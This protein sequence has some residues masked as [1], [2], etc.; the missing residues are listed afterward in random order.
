MM[1]PQ[2]MQQGAG[3][4]PAHPPNPMAVI[5][6]QAQQ[7]ASQAQQQIAQLQSQITIDAV[8]RFFRDENTRSF[9]I[10]IETD[11]TIMPDE[12]AEKQARGEFLQAFG[13]AS[14]GMQP[15]MQMGPSGAELAGVMLKFA[16]APYRAGRQ[17]DTAI[18]KFVEQAPQIVQQQ[19]QAQQ[20][21]GQSQALEQAQQQL[22]QAELGKAQ[23]QLQKTQADAQL[24]AQQLQLDQQRDQSEA[25]HRQQTFSLE[26][27][28][29]QAELQ[30][31]QASLQETLARVEQIQAQTRIE[32]ENARTARQTADNDT[33]RVLIEGGQAAM[34]QAEVMTP[35]LGGQGDGE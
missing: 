10:E 2:L 30:Q 12:A 16:L 5:H 35:D 27:A 15:L 24:K 26:T 32:I 21:S 1:P 6:Q 28:R 8:V 4:G 23:A 14:A 25:V 17:L 13:Q 29:L 18:E 9:A 20:G 7:I 3:Q 31:A 11:S 33:A 22:A 34:A 19:M